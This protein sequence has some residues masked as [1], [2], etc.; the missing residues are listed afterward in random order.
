MRAHKMAASIS[1]DASWVLEISLDVQW[2]HAV[3]P[4][5][6]VLLVEATSTYLG[7]LL[8]AVSYAA[9]TEYIVNMAQSQRIISCSDAV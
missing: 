1:V 5:A 4:N 3:A 7:D 8:S 6:T 2:A 9:S